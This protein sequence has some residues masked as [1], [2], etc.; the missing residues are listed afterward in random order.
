M[1]LAGAVAL[2]AT[3]AAFGQAPPPAAPASAPPSS[4]GW[5]AKN[6]KVLPADISRD[7][8]IGVMRGFT[9]GLGVKC[10]F[11]HVGEDGKRETMDFPSDAKE[12]KLVARKMM[13]MTL[14]LNQQDL[15]VKDMAQAKVTC[16][17]CHRG[18]EKPLTAAPSTAP[19][20]AS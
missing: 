9:A 3:V 4:G 11:C 2:F 14:R 1:I 12:H 10:T 17:T 13:A 20:A 6:L 7:K 15:G 16:F 8:L 5:H 19:P 18:A